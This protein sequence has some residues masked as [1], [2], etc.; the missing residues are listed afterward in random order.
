L[1]ENSRVIVILRYSASPLF[2]AGR[3]APKVR[4]LVSNPVPTSVQ[5]AVR[6]GAQAA[7]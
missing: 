2:A 3:L 1:N 7:I 6:T 4:A 5:N